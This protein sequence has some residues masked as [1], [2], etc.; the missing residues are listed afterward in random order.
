VPKSEKYTEEF[1]M[2]D[3]KENHWVIGA[4]FQNSTLDVKRNLSWE[5]DSM[6]S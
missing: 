6:D 5:F 2:W 4:Q 3:E 1:R